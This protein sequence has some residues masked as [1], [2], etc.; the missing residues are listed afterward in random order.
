MADLKKALK[1]NPAACTLLL[2]EDIGAMV[3]SLYRL[4]NK[5]IMDDLTSNKKKEGAISKS[6][7]PTQQDLDSITM[8]DLS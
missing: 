7:M 4:T 3:Q 2:E 5:A 6:K 8:D 1:E